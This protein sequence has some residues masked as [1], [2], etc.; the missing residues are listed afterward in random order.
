M[1][2]ET[3]PLASFEFMLMEEREK[4]QREE[5]HL[6]LENPAMTVT[7]HCVWT[8][9]QAPCKTEDSFSYQGIPFFV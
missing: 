4:W 6:L 3:L 2:D 8:A 9:L 5:E 7:V 1:H